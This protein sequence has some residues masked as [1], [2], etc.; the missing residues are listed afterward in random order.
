MNLVK[1]FVF[2]A[3]KIKQYIMTENK[4]SKV[5]FDAVVN[6]HKALASGLL[7]NFYETLIKNGIKR[8]INET[9]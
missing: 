3:V 6:L 8:V 5:V 1:T 7:E 2:F 9:L 4:I